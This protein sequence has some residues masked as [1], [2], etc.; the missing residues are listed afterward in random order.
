[1]DYYSCAWKLCNRVSD[2]PGVCIWRRRRK[3]FSGVRIIN[4]SQV[5]VCKWGLMWPCRLCN[6]VS[7]SA[8][9][10]DWR[11]WAQEV[12]QRGAR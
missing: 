2:S 9:V 8:G 1:M 12:L 3:C 11:R 4:D 5:E 10:C 7:D 6:R